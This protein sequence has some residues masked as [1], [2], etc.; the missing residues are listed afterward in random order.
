MSYSSRHQS[1]RRAFVS[2][3]GHATYDNYEDHSRLRPQYSERH[4]VEAHSALSSHGA[5]EPRS[6]TMMSRK[7]TVTRS[8]IHNSSES[9]TSYHHRTE[10][11]TYDSR[12]SP[13]GYRERRHPRSCSCTDCSSSSSDSN[14]PNERSLPDES[15]RD[16]IWRP[17]AKFHTGPQSSAEERRRNPSYAH[18]K[19]SQPKNSEPAHGRGYSSNS[20]NHESNTNGRSD[21]HR[22]EKLNSSS[23]RRK[24]KYHTGRSDNRR[25]E[26]PRRTSN[27]RYYEDREQRHRQEAPQAKAKEKLPDH[28][29]AL[30]LGPL[31]TSE[32]IKSAAKRRRVEVHPDKLKKP[33]MSDSERAKIDA[34][35]AEVGQAADVLSNPEHKLEYDRQ[36]YAAKG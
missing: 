12:Q 26:D 10:Y 6:A 33:G 3:S 24:E 34:A 29:A 20:R 7:V 35:A 31:A 14:H 36:L 4:V 21:D 17:R 1:S 5:R 23:S 27:D 30:K 16:P 28:Y 11:T 15:R 2:D 8:C 13:S 19:H 9:T 32:E 18:A 22:Q 25:E